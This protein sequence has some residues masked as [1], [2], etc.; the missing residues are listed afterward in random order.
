MSKAITIVTPCM[1]NIVVGV[2]EVVIGIKGTMTLHVSFNKTQHIMKA[3]F[4]VQL[5]KFAKKH[6]HC[7]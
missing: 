7:V 1:F 2:K 5:I 4:I 6:M 3:K